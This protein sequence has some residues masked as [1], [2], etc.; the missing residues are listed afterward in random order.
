MVKKDP[1]K[2]KVR[3]TPEQKKAKE[4]YQF[5]EKQEDRYLGSVF[6]NAHGQK[7]Y[8]AKTKAAYERCKRLGMGVE[9]G[10]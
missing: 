10:M 3:L 1:W 9:H 6:A 8:E 4:A 7:Q 2:S 5:A